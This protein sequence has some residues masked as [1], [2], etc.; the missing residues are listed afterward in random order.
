MKKEFF[1]QEVWSSPV[2]SQ[3]E[4]NLEKSGD[5]EEGHLIKQDLLPKSLSSCNVD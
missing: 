2:P 4:N 5:T 1:C 3:K